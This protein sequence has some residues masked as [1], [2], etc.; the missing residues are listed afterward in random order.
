MPTNPFKGVFVRPK[1][2][3]KYGSDRTLSKREKQ[4]KQRAKEKHSEYR[5]AVKA[6]EDALHARQRGQ[7][8]NQP[9]P[10]LPKKPRQF[11]TGSTS[12]SQYNADD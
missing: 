11:K 9:L 3:F 6:R 10:E 8:T 12:L 7:G 1:R 2:V 4:A 5:Q